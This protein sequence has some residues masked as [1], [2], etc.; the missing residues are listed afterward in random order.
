M[1]RYVST[2][3]PEPPCGR[4]Y[5]NFSIAMG[6]TNVITSNN[7][8]LIGQGVWILWGV[9]NCHLPLTSQS[10]LTQGWRYRAARDIAMMSTT[11]IV[12]HQ[13]FHSNHVPQ[14]RSAKLYGGTVMPQ[15][16]C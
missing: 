3:C 6:I 2:I 12:Y 16:D 13:C 9:E 10:P 14:G 4:I 1:N 5:T 8:L 15:N 7:F 11:Q